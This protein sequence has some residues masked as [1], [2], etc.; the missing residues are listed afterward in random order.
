MYKWGLFFYVLLIFFSQSTGYDLYAHSLI[1]YFNWEVITHSYELQDSGIYLPRYGLLSFIYEWGRNFG[2]PIGWVAFSL[3]YFAINDIYKKLEEKSRVHRLMIVLS[4]SILMFFYSALSL[5]LIWIVAAQVTRK[6]LY[7]IASVFH[8][9]SLILVGVY[10][11]YSDSKLKKIS[12]YFFSVS[13]VVALSYI[14]S[15]IFNIANTVNGD[16]VKLSIDIEK[17]PDLII[18]A[19]DLKSNEIN[20]VLLAVVFIFGVRQKIFSLVKAMVPTVL[21]NINVALILFSLLFLSNAIFRITPSPLG[22]FFGGE[23]SDPIYLTWMDFGGRNETLDF[24]TEYDK[25]YKDAY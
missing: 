14:D 23:F 5:T 20:S 9:V 22:V 10:I 19:Y 7:L 17:I 4:T 25:R 18:Y 21:L 15:H 2:V 11:L 13:T 6:N 3:V 16:I 12:I 1:Y 8:P 24:W